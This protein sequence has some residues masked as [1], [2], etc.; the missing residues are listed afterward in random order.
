MPEWVR[1]L[2]GVLFAAGFG[3]GCA[4]LRLPVPAP[5]ALYGALLVVATTAGYL[6]V[7]RFVL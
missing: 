2:L 4:L 5:P 7:Q 3:A 6:L 1:L